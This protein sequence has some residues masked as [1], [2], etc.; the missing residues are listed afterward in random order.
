[1]VTDALFSPDSC[2]IEARECVGR[3]EIRSDKVGSEVDQCPELLDGQAISNA[4]YGMQMLG[5]SEESR[6]LA[7]ALSRKVAE[8]PWSGAEW[9]VALRF[10]NPRATVLVLSLG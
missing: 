4:L 8:A 1:M 3:P 10:D 7:V 6:G 2:S 9:L 5:A